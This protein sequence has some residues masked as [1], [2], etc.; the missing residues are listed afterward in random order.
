MRSSLALAAFASVLSV[1]AANIPI[2]VGANNERHPNGLFYRRNLVV[3]PNAAFTVSS[4]PN[5]SISPST[6]S[7]LSSDDLGPLGPAEFEDLPRY[8]TPASPDTRPT[9]SSTPPIPPKIHVNN[10]SDDID[11]AGLNDKMFY[12]DGRVGDWNPRDYIKKIK[13][14]FV[15]RTGVGENDKVEMFGLSLASSSA[16]EAW[17][18]ALPPADT[19]SWAMLEAAFNKKWPKEAPEEKSAQELSDEMMELELREDEMG[20]K[21]E[22]DGIAVYGHVRWAKRMAILSEKDTTGHMIPMVR[23]KLPPAMRELVN[24]A[25]KTWPEFLKAVREV[26]VQDL[27]EAIEKEKR[28]R[29][30][31]TALQAS[32]T[33]PLRTAFAKA[34]I[35]S[36]PPPIRAYSPS[37]ATP[38]IRRVPAPANPFISSAPIHPSNL[39]A[40]NRP[41][42]NFP[43][44]T[45]S[46][47]MSPAQ[48]LVI[49]EEKILPHHPNTTEGR[50]AYAQQI[51]AYQAEHR[52]LLPTERRPYPLT[53]GTEPLDSG[54]CFNCGQFGHMAKDRD[55]NPT[56]PNPNAIPVPERRWRN[57]ANFIYRMTRRSNPSPPV[58][59]RYVSAPAQPFYDPN[60]GSYF[61][62]DYG[63]DAYAYEYAGEQGKGPGSSE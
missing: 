7:T 48:R 51:A 37:P 63:D 23:K 34:S 12:G 24:N 52:D 25:H 36:Q 56:C 30:F 2:E 55:Q 17:F 40:P 22:V 32:P 14:G 47:Q 54:A 44:S 53:P 61:T 45:P 21:V 28:L 13:R 50:A 15:G 41:S 31:E 26:S 43:P 10:D 19:A 60:T 35:S 39:F 33:A 38:V 58:D 49:L 20:K 27:L 1:Y 59:I 3:D 9:P 4:S 62:L 42:A 46:T 29:A 57:I 6:A 11:M 5:R 16:A 18:D 8:T